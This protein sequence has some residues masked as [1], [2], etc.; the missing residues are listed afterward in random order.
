MYI[1]DSN[2]STDTQINEIIFGFKESENKTFILHD[3]ECKKWNASI[4]SSLI[5][6]LTSDTSAVGNTICYKVSDTNYPA[7]RAF[8]GKK[9]L[10]DAGTGFARL[11]YSIGLEGEPFIGFKFNEQKVVNCYKI[12]TPCVY[13][14]G[15]TMDTGT[16]NNFVFEASNNGIDW[17]ILDKQNNAGFKLPFET[18]EYFINNDKSFFQYRVRSLTTVISICELEMY[19]IFNGDFWS[20]VSTSLPTSTLFLDKGMDNLSTIDRKVTTLKPIA[21]T[22]KS[23]ILGVGEVGKVFSK[24]IDLKKYFD[25]R[26]IRTEV[27]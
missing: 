4:N 6:S 27:K 10:A 8:D 18:K 21:M 24:T 2:G 5:P 9:T 17:V 16:S 13:Q 7:W 22:D 15:T 11:Y 3:G 12:T 20:T 25:I 26:K 14:N 19:Q 1:Y 23:E